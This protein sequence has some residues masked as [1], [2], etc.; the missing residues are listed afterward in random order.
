MRSQIAFK[1]LSLTAARTPP[2]KAMDCGSWPRN[3]SVSLRH[4]NRSPDAPRMEIEVL[5]FL[6]ILYISYLKIV[7]FWIAS[8]LKEL[9]NELRKE[10]LDCF[11]A[12]LLAKTT[13]G[14]FPT[15]VFAS[16]HWG[17]GD[18]ET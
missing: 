6:V 13:G 16:P 1:K 12:K 11:G 2:K 8:A 10:R 17:R 18:P 9:L 7:Y 3:E 14:G 15:A 5:I 4:W